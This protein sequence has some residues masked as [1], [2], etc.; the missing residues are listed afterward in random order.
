MF[1]LALFAAAFLCTIATLNLSVRSNTAKFET[2]LADRVL[3][4]RQLKVVADAYAVSI[5][6]A[7]HKARNGNFT[8]AEAERRVHEGRARAAENWKAY[9]ATSIK[10]HEAELADQTE[11]QIRKAEAEVDALEQILN[12]K[13]RAALD[14]FVVRRLYAA[15]DPVSDAMSALVSEQIRIAGEVTGDAGTFNRHGGL[16]RDRDWYRC[17]RR[18]VFRASDCAQEHHPAD[19]YAGGRDGSAGRY[20]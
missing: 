1:C 5:V 19:R 12:R 10:G 20:T 6:D 7:S 11:A 18:V 14:A 13:D 9:R 15:I 4:L 17:G 3:P 8:M 2:L 16:D